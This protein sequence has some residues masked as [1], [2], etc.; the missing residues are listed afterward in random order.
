MVEEEG[1][2]SLVCCIPTFLD[3]ARGALG[4][5]NGLFAVRLEVPSRI[6]SSSSENLAT[7]DP[8][9]P[10][11]SSPPS[12]GRLSIRAFAVSPFDRAGNERVNVAREGWSWM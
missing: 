4:G 8:G 6:D 5:E 10:E 9:T 12:C 7:N 3:I 11:T 1:P 2:S